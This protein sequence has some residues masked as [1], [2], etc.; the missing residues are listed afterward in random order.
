MLRTVLVLIIPRSAFMRPGRY[1]SR[2]CLLVSPARGSHA[3]DLDGRVRGPLSHGLVAALA[4]AGRARRAAPRR[5]RAQAREPSP[6]DVEEGPRDDECDRDCLP[7]KIHHVNLGPEACRP[8]TSR[9]T[10]RTR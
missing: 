3:A 1:R 5:E 4:A 2:L 10:R 8:G 9:T 7:V 6:R